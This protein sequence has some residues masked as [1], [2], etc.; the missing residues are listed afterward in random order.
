MGNIAVV[1]GKPLPFDALEFDPIV[2]AGDVLYDLAFLLMDLVERGLAAPAN[3]VLNTYFAASH[4][5]EDLEALADVAAIPLA[6]RRD[7]RQGDG[8][9]GRKH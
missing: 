8:I 6:A 3:A 9:E 4:R 1:D 7:P 2:A 5:A